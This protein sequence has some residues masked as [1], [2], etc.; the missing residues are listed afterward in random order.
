MRVSHGCIRLYPEGIERLFGEVGVKTP[1]TIVDQPFKVGWRGGD[2]YLEVNATDAEK[3]KP[4]SEI[5]PPAVANAQG[6]NVDWDEVRKAVAANTG[7]PQ[8]VGGRQKLGD[9]LYLRMIF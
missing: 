2:L 6:V 4:L 3:G 1:V 9:Q 5:I 7:L 8:L